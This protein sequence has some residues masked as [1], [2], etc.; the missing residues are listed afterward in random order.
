[1][2]DGPVNGL[3]MRAR[4]GETVGG[5]VARQRPGAR[6]RQNLVWPRVGSYE[7]KL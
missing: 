3:K 2:K 7:S 1:M 4:G 6:P 5:L